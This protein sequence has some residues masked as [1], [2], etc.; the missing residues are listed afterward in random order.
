MFIPNLCK[1]DSLKDFKNAFLA[2]KTALKNL[3]MSLVNKIA[4]WITCMTWQQSE[5][6]VN[7]ATFL[8]TFRNVVIIFIK[9]RFTA[10]FFLN[11]VFF[12]HHIYDYRFITSRKQ[13][14][15]LIEAWQQPHVESACTV[16]IMHI[17]TDVQDVPKNLVTLLFTITLAFVDWF[18]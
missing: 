13:H 11:F 8:S 9:M 10:V 3:L 17:Y 2:Y 14:W 18:Q 4:L 12:E 1:L 6:I 5:N 16:G 15:S 7:Q